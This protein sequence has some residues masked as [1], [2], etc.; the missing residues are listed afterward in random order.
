MHQ[1]LKDALEP[2]S[3]LIYF[4]TILLALK[5]NR[6]PQVM[7]LLFYYLL[8]IPLICS[9]VFIINVSRNV[10]IYNSFFF[11]TICVFSYYFHSILFNSFRKVIIV[12][13]FIINLGLFIGFDLLH[14]GLIKVHTPFYAITY[15][16]V[17]IYSL[18]YF[19]QVMSNV[20]EM[21]LLLQF[22]FWLVSGY[23]LYYFG[24]FFIILFY[25]NVEINDR[26]IIWSLQNVI[27]FISSVL[28]LSGSLWISRHR[29]F[30]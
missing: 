2:L 1:I 14:G 4:I 5:T 6:S 18:V 29:Q 8:A 24:S 9:A 23:L 19:E 3:Y 16:S 26:A 22:N 28:T 27:L 25:D 21:N 12:I 17:V 30:S 13:I 10:A 7:V 11:L 15:L 20:S